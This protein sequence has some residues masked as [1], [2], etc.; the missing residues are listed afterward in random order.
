VVTKEEEEGTFCSSEKIKEINAVSLTSWL[1]EA[2]Q[3][4]LIRNENVILIL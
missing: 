1:G 2:K 3:E 4:T